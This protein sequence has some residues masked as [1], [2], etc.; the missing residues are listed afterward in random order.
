MED[1]IYEFLGLPSV[2]VEHEE[3][4][5]GRHYI[6][7]PGGERQRVSKFNVRTLDT[8]THKFGY[9]VI[10]GVVHY[11]GAME[12]V[13]KVKEKP[14]GGFSYEEIEFIRR[15]YLELREPDE[16]GKIPSKTEVARQIAREFQSLYEREIDPGLFYQC[17]CLHSGRNVY[18]RY[19]LREG[20]DK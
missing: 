7:P 20:E 8:Q 11:W 14:G 18:T 6:T 4:P 5:D 1:Q 2:E 16:N 15:A 10:K 17:F 19:D 13:P 12:L 9:I 3:T